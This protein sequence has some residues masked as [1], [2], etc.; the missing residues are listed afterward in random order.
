MSDI[1]LDFTVSNNSIDF[2]VQPNDITIT[3][4]E[5][6]LT[7]NAN[8]QPLAGGS[9]FQLQFNNAGVLGGVANTYY[10]A[11]N[12]LLG[13]VAN[14]KITG[15][16]NGY[17]LQTDGTGNLDWTAMT[18][19][20][21]NG[22]P[23]GSNTQIQYNDAGT[24]GGNSGF[25][26]N[27][28]T[29]NVA[30]P[31][32]LSVTGNI[33]GSITNSNFANFAGNVTVSTQP[34]ITSLGTLINLSVTGNLTSGNANLGNLAIANYFSGDGGLLSNLSTGTGISNGTSN[35]NIPLA[36]GNIVASVNGNAN[37]FVITDTGANV[38]GTFRSTGN[39]NVGNLS[40]TGL[41]TTNANVTSTLIV[42]SQANIANLT[43]TSGFGIALGNGAS[44]V[45]SGVAL[46]WNADAK[47]ANSVAI[48]YSSQ[49]NGRGT[50]VGFSA[51]LNTG[52]G[53]SSVD[54]TFVGAHA[55]Q[56]GNANAYGAQTVVGSF[57]GHR[58]DGELTV[59]IGAYAG[60][61]I[62]SNSVT[63]IGQAEGAIAIGALAGQ[64]NQNVGA[65][66]IGRTS[67]SNNQGQY[68]IAI[69]KGSG[70]AQANNSITLDATNSN[71]SANIANSFFVKPIRDVTSEA[72][73]TVQ[74]YY[75]PTTGEIGY[76]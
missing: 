20:G 4:E 75:N 52:V 24:F 45:A 39:A 41:S 18:G 40:T 43:I 58:L 19:G 36:N 35:I 50:S 5:I 14:I 56:F 1:N 25:T 62:Y 31:G 59:A 9:P 53:G 15:G 11:G 46:G 10:S 32:N 33:I 61:G 26:F 73:F 66:A 54:Q 16:T 48:G 22:T 42:G 47:I 64:T 21:G 8:F 55:G 65:I 67:G 30:I 13:D 63:A 72:G 68:S 29:G 49:A 27:E 44:A 51:G 69:G 74:L 76:K 38:N 6:Q 70:N 3:P 37:I 57:A 17:V 12:L 7:L 71:L 23:G 34:N 28:V 60:Y 2:T